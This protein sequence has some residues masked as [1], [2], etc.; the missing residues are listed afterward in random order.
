MRI[1][2]EQLLKESGEDLTFSDLARDMAK[3]G[4]FKNVKSAYD[5]IHYH[6]NGK[7]K[8][9]DWELLKYL[10]TRFKKKGAEIIEWDN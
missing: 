8:G 10:C 1:N 6:I 4:L 2:F 9:C 5:M 3:E 7:A